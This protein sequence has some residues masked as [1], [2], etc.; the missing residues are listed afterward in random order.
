MVSSL[1]SLS[2]PSRDISLTKRRK[3]QRICDFTNVCEVTIRSTNCLRGSFLWILD[4]T[5]GR[6]NEKGVPGRLL[7]ESQR[8]CFF[9]TS[10]CFQDQFDN[11]PGGAMPAESVSCEV[12]GS[13]EFWRAIGHTDSQSCSPC[14]RNV[15]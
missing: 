12:T 2:R 7:C 3:L 5:R 10:L 13:F 6:P 9:P 4:S 11:F 14:K 15:R 1:I 8:E